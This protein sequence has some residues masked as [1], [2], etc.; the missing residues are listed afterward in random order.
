MNI[1]GCIFDLGE[2]LWI[3]IREHLLYHLKIVSKREMYC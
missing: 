1:R 3:N 2:Q